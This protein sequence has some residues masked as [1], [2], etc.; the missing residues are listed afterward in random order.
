MR[1]GGCH[2]REAARRMRAMRRTVLEADV[3]HW[4]TAFLDALD[5]AA[6]HR[7]GGHPDDGAAP[8]PAHDER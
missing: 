7:D 6:A 3:H 8:E 4:A 1:R 5:A 2:P